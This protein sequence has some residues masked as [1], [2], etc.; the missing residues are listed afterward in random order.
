MSD[1]FKMQSPWQAGQDKLEKRVVDL[2]IEGERTFTMIEGKD[3][4]ERMYSLWEDIND[5]AARHVSKFPDRRCSIETTQ[6]VSWSYVV[7]GCVVLSVI[8]GTAV[9]C[10]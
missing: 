4:R 9:C 2:E 5:G 10:S 7:L 6:E 8:V 3:M 1:E